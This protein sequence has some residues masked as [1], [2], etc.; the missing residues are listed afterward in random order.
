MITVNLERIVLIHPFLLHYHYP[1]LEALSDKC[2]QAGISLFNIEL[3][4]YCDTYRSLFEERENR[5][6]NR[7]LFPGQNLKD[8]PWSKMWPSLRKALD[9]LRPD[10]IFLY[11][12]S[13]RVMRQAKLWAE[14]RNI[15]T[16]LMS[17]SNEFDGN[18][19]R[20]FEFI[21]SLFVSRFDAAF[22]GGSSSS[23][24]LQQ[25]GIPKERIVLGW[26]VVDN[27]SF[28]RQA[29]ENRK[30]ISQVRRKWNLPEAYF[31]FVG[32]MV[33]NKNIRGLL[34]AYVEYAESM[35]EESKPW[36]LVICGSGPEEEELQRRVKSMPGQL[37]NHVQLYGVVKQPKLTDF[38]SGASCLILP[39]TR[40]ESWGLVVNEAMACGLPVIVSSRC[41]CSL[42]LV[43]NGINGWRFDP[44]SSSELV[45]WMLKLHTLDPSARAEMGLQGEHIISDWG[46]DRFSRGALESAQIALDYRKP[47]L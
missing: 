38:F 6:N 2:R 23:L 22:V 1:R 13:L 8:I 42:D 19:N 46:L 14:K 15:A 36:D 39:S 26:D 25:L 4:S 20:L 18:R 31:L 12:Y 33:R 40:Y 5:P 35:G 44:D 41:G 34:E 28:R 30:D 21:K 9:E 16:V 32:R 47:S 7:T 11:G 27:E 43:R 3:A 45:S 29:S 17:D 37:G 10:V 24:Y